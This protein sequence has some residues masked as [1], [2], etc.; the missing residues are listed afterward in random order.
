MCIRDRLGALSNMRVFIVP[1]SYFSHQNLSFDF[2]NFLSAACESIS[3]I[4]ADRD[5]KGGGVFVLEK[6]SAHAAA[7]VIDFTILLADLSQK[8]SL[9]FLTSSSETRILLKTSAPFLASPTEQITSRARSTGWSFP[10]PGDSTYPVSY[11]HLD[12]YK[13]QVLR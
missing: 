11:T 4:R 2:E 7:S 12:V 1:S 3:P 6:A 8:G 9:A 10:Y 13:R 5:I